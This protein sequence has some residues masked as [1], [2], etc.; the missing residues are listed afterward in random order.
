MSMSSYGNENKHFERTNQSQPRRNVLVLSE[1]SFQ[2]HLLL[3]KR[4]IEDQDFMIDLQE[5]RIPR[6]AG[7]DDAESQAIRKDAEHKKEKA[8]RKVPA[9]EKF[10]QELS[11]QW[12]TNKSRILGH[13]IFSP[14]IIVGAGIELQYTQDLAVVEVDASKINPGDFPGNFIDLGTKYTPVELT[15]KMHPNSKNSRNFTFPGDHL[16]TLFGTIPKEEM[17]N[18]QMW[19][20]DGEACIMVLKRGRTTDLTVGRATTFVSYTRKYF[21]EH[22]TAMSKEW[23]IIPL[24]K[25]SGPFSAEGNSGSVVVDELGRIGGIITSGSGATDSSDITYVTPIEF[26]MDVIHKFKL[27]ASTYIKNAQP[28]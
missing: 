5:R 18:P 12:S 25:E 7:W 27:L 16:L 13:I 8:E 15:R 2:Q 23:A 11:V 24:D 21:S 20:K 1:N 26:I 14:E 22:D 17:R 19:D 9:L 28:T 10:L 6:V 4:D 3:I